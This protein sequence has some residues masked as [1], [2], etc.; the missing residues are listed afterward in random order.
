MHLS[1]LQ[2]KQLLLDVMD[3][4]LQVFLDLD[5]HLVLLLKCLVGFFKCS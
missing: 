1:L 3:S 5:V 4:L 2:L